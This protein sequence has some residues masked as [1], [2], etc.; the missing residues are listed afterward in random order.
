[1]KIKP[2]WLLLVI[3]LFGAL[4]G[5]QYWAGAKWRENQGPEILVKDQQNN[6][7][8]SFGPSIFR[9]DSEGH[10]VEHRDLR[11]FGIEEILGSMAFFPNGDVLMVPQN[12]HAS[13][14][15][16]I[17]TYYRISQW[18]SSANSALNGRLSRCDWKTLH[19]QPLP[20]FDEAFVRT[21]WT[22]IDAD[23]NIFLAD[24]SRHRLYWLDSR[25][26]V[27]DTIYDMDNLQ[28][29]N[30]IKHDGDKLLVAN[31]NNNS[32]TA[33]GLED[34]K[35]SRRFHHFRFDGSQIMRYGDRWTAGIVTLGDDYY[36]LVQ[37]DNMMQGSVYRMS[38]DGKIKV[39]F[40]RKPDADP[41]GI[42]TFRNE[43]L[44]ADYHKVRV[45]RF[46]INGKYL[47]EFSSPELQ[48]VF[49]PMRESQ[50]IFVRLEYVMKQLFWVALLIGFIAAYWLEIRH[51]KNASIEQGSLSVAKG[52]VSIPPQVDDAR[53]VWIEQRWFIR[54]IN[55]WFIWFW[56][57]LMIISLPALFSAEE[58]SVRAYSIY[59]ALHGV[60]LLEYF[61]LRR[62]SQFS[63]GALSPWI[64]F[65]DFH[66]HADVV[67]ETM[68]TRY[69][70]GFGSILMGRNSEIVVK[71]F[72][73]FRVFA[74]EQANEYLDRVLLNAREVGL[75]E[76]L[77]WLVEKRLP[78]LLWAIGWAIF[79]IILE[80]TI[81]K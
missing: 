77:L 21:L 16:N 11:Q 9:F 60:T 67:H 80:I 79:Y 29:P 40:E 22:D 47:G 33:V 42:V 66:G 28:F 81:R 15:E 7:Y 4:F 73:F 37:N 41:I 43:I 32:L 69:T 53:I 76:R 14:L 6:L 20:S 3:V 61:R 58:E 46:N 36:V 64:V 51:K 25:G 44:V 39:M 18:H 5:T 74:G 13:Y 68:L 65:R 38:R 27:L 52:S 45:D 78:A 49:E 70:T 24:T 48:A 54:N 2:I 10:F 31:S 26:K 62:S 8:I 56:L 34:K 30:Q 75:K 72:G 71:K 50:R 19:C 63:I 12:Q 1:M 59:I 17:L 23:E 57:P 35:F 55:K